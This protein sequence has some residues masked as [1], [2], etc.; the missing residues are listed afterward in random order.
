MILL[1]MAAAL[2]ATPP[3]TCRPKD[4]WRRQAGQICF[5][6]G[7]TLAP[8]HMEAMHR[9]LKTLA[10][11]KGELDPPTADAIRTQAAKAMAAKGIRRRYGAPA[12]LAP[13]RQFEVHPG[14]RTTPYAE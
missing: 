5:T 3:I 8:A 12:G 1:L 6:P 13:F 2:A 7:T 11:A 14:P 4:L 9:P 10:Q